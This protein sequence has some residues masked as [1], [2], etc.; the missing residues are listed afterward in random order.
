MAVRLGLAALVH[1]EPRVHPVLQ[2]AGATYLLYL[3][4]RTAWADAGNG[5]IARAKPISFAE[6]ALFQWIKPKGWVFALGALAAYTTVGGN[7]LLETSIIATVN[8]AAC[9]LSVVIWA[10]FGVVIGRFL[11]HPRVRKVFNWT[12]AGLL[13]LSLLPVFW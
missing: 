11:D 9:L 13:V 2:Y 7:V 8:A 4:W 1:A 5:A 10:G 3:A 12:M 6:A